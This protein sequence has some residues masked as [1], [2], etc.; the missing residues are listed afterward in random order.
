VDD[1]AARLQRFSAQL[2]IYLARAIHFTAEVLLA[3][4]DHLLS[5]FGQGAGSGLIFR[6]G[7]LVELL[8]LRCSEDSAEQQ[9]GIAARAGL[10]DKRL[11]EVMAFL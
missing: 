7:R 9:R 4:V 10:P 6:S 1:T 8:R 3:L 11:L 2:R 5:A